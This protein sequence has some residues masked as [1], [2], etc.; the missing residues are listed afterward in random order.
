MPTKTVNIAI[1]RCCFAEDRQNGLVRKCVPHVQHA[2][3]SSLDQSKPVPVVDAKAPSQGAY[4]AT[5]AKATKTS[6]LG[7]GDFIVDRSRCKWT[8]RSAV[9]VNI[10]NERFAV[11]CSRCR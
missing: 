1:L 9:E 6:H 3:F 8:G 2:Y 11:V 10:E 4:A 5:T 7:N